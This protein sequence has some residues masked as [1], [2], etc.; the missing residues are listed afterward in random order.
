MSDE[1]RLGELPGD[2]ADLHHRLGAAEG[3]HDRHLQEHP[4]EVA[5]IVG[6]M[7]G[8]AF[9]AIAALQQETLAFADIRQLVL[10]RARFTCKNQRRIGAQTGLDRFQCFR[11]RIGRDLQDRFVPP[12]VRCP[13]LCHCTCS[14]RDLRDLS[15]RGC[16]ARRGDA[17][18]YGNHRRV[19]RGNGPF[20]RL[21]RI[22]ML[23]AMCAPSNSSNRPRS[24]SLVSTWRE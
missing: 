23:D 22:G 5:D 24:A 13:R 18:L 11:V 1:P 15:P 8:E 21:Q 3:Q 20:W 14:L 19:S 7:L 12:T 16:S 4:E 10:Q 6:A 17:P 2:P 9:G